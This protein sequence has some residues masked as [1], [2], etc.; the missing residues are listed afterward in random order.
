MSSAIGANMIHETQLTDQVAVVTGG[1]SGIGRATCLALASAGAS[2]VV[3]DYNPDGVRQTLDQLVGMGQSPLGITADVRSQD[4]VETMVQQVQERFGRIDILVH[5][6]A[7]LRIQDSGPRI[8]PDVSPE[9]MHAVIDTN[10]KGTFLCNR[11]VLPTMIRQGSGQII[12]ISSTS[13]KKGRPFDSVY[14]ASKFGMLGLS[15]SLAE[16]VRQYGIR[17]QVILPDAVDTPLWDQ[18]RPI[19]PPDYSLRPDRVADMITYML[20]LPRD[21]ILENVIISPFRARKR[22]SRPKPQPDD[23]SRPAATQASQPGPKSAEE[24]AHDAPH[25]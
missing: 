20:M 8:L 25:S 19:G 9:E 5:S 6:A 12:N 24:D 10:L 21:T 22:K 15:E 23:V 13:G 17:V 18:N 14:C 11:A 7:I 4:D 3:V 16:E 2:V 1:G